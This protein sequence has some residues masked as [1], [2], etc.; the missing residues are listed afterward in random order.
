MLLKILLT[1]IFLQSIVG[2]TK[3]STTCRNLGDETHEKAYIYQLKENNVEFHVNDQNLIC[4]DTLMWEGEN[5]SKFENQVNTFYRGVAEMLTNQD[6]INNVALWLETE[7]IPHDF[8]VSS[9]G[10]FLVIYSANP[11]EAE[12]NRNK[13]NSVLN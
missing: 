1:Y 13:L 5:Y 11:Q 7:N 9:R 4:M 3:T 2:C 6:D 8:S 12:E 10:T